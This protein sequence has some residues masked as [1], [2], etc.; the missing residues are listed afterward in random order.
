MTKYQNNIQDQR[1][2]SLE[3]KFDKMCENHAHDISSI[4][5]DIAS[6]KANQKFLVWFMLLQIGAIVSLWIK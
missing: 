1:I 6:I 3:D 4:R 2:T 5:E